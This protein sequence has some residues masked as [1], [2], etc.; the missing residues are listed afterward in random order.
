MSVIDLYYT[1]CRQIFFAVPN[2]QQL[3]L[4]L[5][6]EDDGGTWKSV[7]ANFVALLRVIIK[8]GIASC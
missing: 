4:H 7:G 3:R 2:C 8:A 1:M 5:K 6:V